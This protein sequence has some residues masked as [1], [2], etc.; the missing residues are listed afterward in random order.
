MPTPIT[1][2]IVPAAAS[3]RAAPSAASNVPAWRRLP[4]GAECVPPD[5]GVGVH[6]RVWAPERERVEVVL[7]PGPA[8]PDGATLPLTREPRESGH[9]SGVVEPARA[10]SRYRL[11]LD[12]G[13]AYPD[14]ATRFQPEGPHGPSEVVDA[15]AFRWSDSAWRGIAPERH[16]VYELHL[17]TFTSEGTWAGAMARLPHLASLGVT[18]LEIMPIAQFPGRFNWGYDGTHLFAP[19]VQY[20]TPDDMRRFVDAAHAHGLAVILDVVYN[21]LGPSGNYLPQFSPYWFN[22][23]HT[24]DWGD[25][26]NYDGPHAHGVREFVVSNGAYWVDEFH[27]DGLRLDATQAIVDESPR[28]V[29]AEL[30][31]AVRRVARAA[32]RTWTWIVNENEEQQIRLVQPADV[33]G[34]CALDAIWNDDFHHAARVALT[35]RD[36]AYFTDYR[37]RASEFVAAVK[38]GFL[39]QGQWYRWQ[40][41]RRGTPTFGTPPWRFVH[42]LQNHDQIAN[43]GTGERL[44]RHASPHRIRA[45]TTLLLLGPQ[46]P[47]LFQGQEWGT[48]V[49]FVFF[50]DHEPDLAPLVHA[51]RFAEMTQHANL[52]Q[53][54]ME[55]YLAV[56]HEERSF[57]RCVLDWGEPEEGSHAPLLAMHRALLA[58]RREDPVLARPRTGPG[59]A[60]GQ[61]DAAAIAERT[62][63]VRWFD[64][65]GDR[66]LVVNLDGPLHYDPAPEPLLAPPAGMRWRLAFSSEDPRWGGLGTAP[67]DAA[68]APRSPPRRPELRWPRE[69][70]RVPGDCAVFLVPEPHAGSAGGEVGA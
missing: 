51:G 70:W 13:E 3:E 37:G 41:Q 21:H 65:A 8:H 52:A 18:T 2:P 36:E 9:W 27:L 44:Q 69:N 40:R 1:E 47:L 16:V 22:P 31:D 12:G 66:L 5:A 60:D 59:C 49:P 19:A 68:E 55:D 53:P 54:G 39:Y 67:P 4:I 20:G 35:G 32:G 10:G 38:H 25:A 14:P 43:S 50:A 24:T 61:I 7:E 64:A 58:L 62:F 30:G 34:G 6:L 57:A 63:V 11:R 48:R 29:L 28:H 23:A 45:L 42:F 46:T 15:G 17:G 56:P 26:L 33:P